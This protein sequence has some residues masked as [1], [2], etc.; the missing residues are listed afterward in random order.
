M[1]ILASPASRGLEEFEG[2]FVVDDRV[3]AGKTELFLTALRQD[4]ATS[5]LEV[6]D[7]VIPKRS[8]PLE[9]RQLSVYILVDEEPKEGYQA[10]SDWLKTTI[11]SNELYRKNIEFKFQ[12]YTGR[13]RVVEGYKTAVSGLGGV[14]V[15]VIE[16]L[17]S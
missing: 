13:K 6:L 2:L 11:K 17:K 8:A 5:L 7:G 9:D 1:S 12:V 10:V 3:H 4:P 16:S 15:D 14:R